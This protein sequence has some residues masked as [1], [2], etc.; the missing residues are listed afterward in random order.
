M[1]FPLGGRRV[2]VAGHRGM[3]GSAIVRALRPAG[4]RDPGGAPAGRGSPPAGGGGELD[5]GVEA[6]RGVPGRSPG[7][8]HPGQR[9]PARGVPLRQSGDRVRGHRERPP[10]RGEEAPVPG[11]ELHLS[12]GGSAADGGRGVAGRPPGADQRMVRGGQDRRHQALPGI[13]APVRLQ[14]HLAHA[15]QPLRP[16]RQLRSRILPR[17]PGADAQDARGPRGRPR[18]GGGLGSGSPRREF[19]HVDD[20]AE[21]GPFT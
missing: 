16:R 8:R 20:L 13:P 15:L 5:A 14:L 19:L 6:G 11:V 18:G 4:L 3:V 10:R 21:A 7:R 17:D 9:P 1:D 2:F 12:Q